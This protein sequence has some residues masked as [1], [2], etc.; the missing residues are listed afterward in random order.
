MGDEEE[1]PCPGLRLLD[2]LDLDRGLDDVL[3]H[4][5]V[6][7][8]VEALEA[9]AD[10]TPLGRDVLVGEVVQRDALAEIEAALVES[11][12]IPVCE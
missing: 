4:G 10:L 12:P 7:E 9:H 8:E 3:E 1:G 11:L 6:G 2:A 5:L